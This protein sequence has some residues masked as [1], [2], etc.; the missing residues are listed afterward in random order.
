MIRRTLGYEFYAVDDDK[1]PLELDPAYGREMARS[2]T[3]KSRSLH[4]DC[5]VAEDAGG[6]EAQRAA[7]SCP[8]VQKPAVYLAECAWDLREARGM[9]E[10]ELRILGYKTLPDCELPRE[11]ERYSAEVR[12]LLA[13]CNLSIHIVG[14][15]PGA[16]PDGP[17]HQ[18]TLVLQN[19][20]AIERS[21]EV[22]LRRLI[23]LPP[24]VVGKTRTSSGSSSPCSAIRLRSSE[25]T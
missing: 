18:C 19:Q 7:R 15:S 1:T 8:C 23:W 5:S 14:A 4:R 6:G 17:S 2:T 11:E 3:S 9:L 25:P 24:G 20:L 13:Q 21:K 12:R 22:G 10:T 16:V